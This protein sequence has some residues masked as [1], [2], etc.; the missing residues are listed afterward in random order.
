[1][2]PDKSVPV[3]MPALVLA[4]GNSSRLGRPKQ[5]LLYEGETLLHRAVR[6]ALAAGCAPVLV[7]SGALDAEL[8]AAVADLPCQFVHNPVWATGLGSSVAAGADALLAWAATAPNP[9]AA[10]LLLLCDQPLLTADHLKALIARQRATGSAAVASAYAGVAGVPVVFGAALFD[11]LRRLDG[12]GGAGQLL[13]SLPPA[14]LLTLD[15]PA[16]A[17]DVDTPAQYAQ[18]LAINKQL[19]CS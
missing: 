17:L 19:T 4:A 5:T 8:R 18:L 12:V 9:P 11:R 7:V 13:K 15:F 1:M 6:T 3:P 2:T 10:L 16:A 14:E